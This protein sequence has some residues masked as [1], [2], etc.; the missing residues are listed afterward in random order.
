MALLTALYALQ[1]IPLGLATGAVPFLVQANAATPAAGL[2]AAGGFALAAWPY[3]SKLAWAPIVDA[4][5]PAPHWRRRTWI[6]PTQA[7]SAGLMWCGAG[8]AENALQAGHTTALTL[9]FFA[10]VAAAATQDIAVDG[11]ALT[12]LSRKRVGVASTCQTLGTGAGA[13]LSFAGLVALSDPLFCHR[14]LGTPAAGPAAWSLGGYLRAW[15]LI[16]GVATV[17]LVF[18]RERASPPPDWVGGAG[19]GSEGEEE[20]GEGGGEEA[21]PVA[22]GRGRGLGRWWGEA[23][24]TGYRDL[25][26]VAALPAVRRLMGL[27]LVNRLAVLPAEAA[28]TLALLAKGVPRDALAGLAAAQLPAEWVAA[29]LAGRASA[30]GRPGGLARAWAA[31]FWARLACAGLATGVAVWAAPVAKGAAP[32][33]ALL[34]AAGAGGLATAATAALQ[35]TCLGALYA[36]VADPAQGGA[37]LTLLNTVANMGAFVCEKGEGEK[38]T[39][40]KEEGRGNGVGEWRQGIEKAGGRARLTFSLMPFSHSLS[41]SHTHTRT[42]ASPSQATPSPSPS[43][44][45]PSPGGA[46]GRFRASPWRPGPSRVRGGC[47]KSWE[48]WRGCRPL[49]GGWGRGGGGD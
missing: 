20:E 21:G 13:F 23:A 42:R 43:P 3:A 30:S 18:V 19:E 49:R 16:Y 46:W 29:A 9:F 44:W 24:A 14:W 11:W 45:P 15:G 47:V 36:R 31:G 41:L 17:A 40:G 4:A 5:Y 48:S 1:G 28:A 27:L 10:L 37:Y 2:A 32:P 22:R 34:L 33:T 26:R 12:L 8:F 35:F 38:E 6:L 7:L 39:R 25:A